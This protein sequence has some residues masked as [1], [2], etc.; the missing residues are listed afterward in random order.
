MSTYCCGTETQAKSIL[1]SKYGN[2]IQL[3]VNNLLIID[4]FRE[5]H[6][7]LQLFNQSGLGLEYA[8]VKVNPDQFKSSQALVQIVNDQL[9]L[10]FHID[11]VF[12]ISVV[13]DAFKVYQEPDICQFI[14]GDIHQ[15][16]L[17]AVDQLKLGTLK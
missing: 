14:S 9:E 6:D 2:G 7:Q 11:P 8:F 12:I 17:K 10:E 13:P 15:L 5:H 1:Y 3:L 16:I 4:N